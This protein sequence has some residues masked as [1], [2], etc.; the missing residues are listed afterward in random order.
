MA[1]VGN[2]LDAVNK[3]NSFATAAE[4]YAE[5][6]Q[7]P[8]AVEA[9]FRAAEQ[10]L[11]ATSYT[12]DPEAVKT[13]K[14]LYSNH[15]RQGKDLQRR[16]QAR[17]AASPASA[18]VPGSPAIGQ[19]HPASAVPRMSDPT[20]TT[21]RGQKLIESFQEVQTPRVSSPLGRHA[22]T[23][24]PPPQAN[25]F[26][27]ISASAYGSQNFFVGQQRAAGGSGDS[28]LFTTSRDPPRHM[29]SAPGGRGRYANDGGEAATVP[30]ISLDVSGQLGRRGGRNSAPPTIRPALRNPSD[31]IDRSYL[32]L[33]DRPEDLS[34]SFAAGLG[35]QHP[36]QGEDEPE[37]PFNKFWDVVENL[38]QRI[39]VPAPVAFATAPLVA[40]QQAGAHNGGRAT[41]PY[42]QGWEERRAAA[43]ATGGNMTD[44]LRTNALLNSY[45]VVGGGEASMA[46]STFGAEAAAAAAAAGGVGPHHQGGGRVVSYDA[47]VGAANAPIGGG[48]ITN[49]DRDA[50]LP[51]P[52]ATMMDAGALS[53]DSNFFGG[54]G[55]VAGGVA[56]RPPGREGSPVITR[57]GPV[58]VVGEKTVEELHVENEQLKQTV[59]FLTRRMALLE[60]AAEENTM[61]RSSII[62]FRQD[63]QKQAK[64]FGV[65]SLHNLP[66]PQTANPLGGSVGPHYTRKPSTGVN[67]QSSP[68]STSP[69]SS[70][71]AAP[72]LP[73][74]AHTPSA[75]TAELAARIESLERELQDVR[76]E[77][78][79]RAAE[80]ERWRERWSKLKESQRRKRERK[81]A[82]G[83]EGNSSIPASPSIGVP[84]SG[85]LA[86]Q[87]SGVRSQERASTGSPVTLGGYSS[88]AS[89]TTGS[90]S[91]GGG[92]VAGR[93]EEEHYGGGAG[94][95]A[96]GVHTS[97]HQGVGGGATT[98]PLTSRRSSGASLRS[99]T[100]TTS[101]G[102]GSV[103]SAEAPGIPMPR[104]GSA[105]S[106]GSAGA[107]SSGS[108]VMGS[109]LGRRGGGSVR[110]KERM[111][112]SAMGGK[113]MEA[114][115]AT[116]MGGSMFYSFVDGDGGIE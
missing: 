8:K 27:E 114:S 38:V 78:E 67:Q 11:L 79:S 113:G 33:G 34:P 81:E 116:T 22:S 92:I 95:R 30:V 85:G 7:Y 105:G 23:A 96:D 86:G 12:S 44:T 65:T 61:L 4:D 104:S 115:Q 57:E 42:Y 47:G 51:A 5:R 25:T 112:R 29:T 40:N 58:R 68:I 84:D 76:L 41:M 15:T 110:G 36:Q 21:L 10:F 48:F 75:G 111:D 80:I 101:L 20:E 1:D 94:R 26:E 91:G 93:V 109:Q 103:V 62:Q 49:H 64:R 88:D 107:P 14:L 19:P 59:D 18:R 6:G 3:G 17:L 72:P 43:A 102:G 54:A 28:V 52:V 98:F 45:F 97:A 82:E 16:I 99:G 108:V 70:M 69:S 56:V 31:S 89:S 9:H 106:F 24:A 37:D 74:G 66:P 71:S 60:R 39:S 100:S 2:N 46:A 55:T 53:V 83:V 50:A 32:V 90:A 77:S 73:G 13:L 63:L 87:L 35:G